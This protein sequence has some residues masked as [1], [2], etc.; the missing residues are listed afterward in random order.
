MAELDARLEGGIPRG[1]VSEVVGPRS[2]GRLAILVSALAAATSRGEAVALI[3]PLDMFDPVSA[4]AC[5]L[6]FQRMLWIRGEASSSARVSLSCE[7]GT[8]QKSLDRAVKALNIVLQAGGFGV[9]VLDLGEVAAQTIKR[10]PYTTWLRLHRVIEG[11]ETACVLIGSE[12]IARSAGGVTVQLTPGWAPGFGLER[13]CHP[14]PKSGERPACSRAF[15]CRRLLTRCT[16]GQ[17]QS[18]PDGQWEHRPTRRATTDRATHDPRALVQIARDFS[19]RVETHGD[20]TVTLDISGLGSLIGSPRSIGEELRR[21][22][23]DAGLCVHIAVASTST[24]AI[25]LAHA[26]AGVTVVAP[27][28]RSGGARA[29]AA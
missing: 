27:A 22:A 19:P 8:L 25:L 16:S 20:R 17:R 4:S 14:S 7:Y 12:P 29:V 21:T 24:T 3:D 13:A 5:G 9:V 15:I 1:H 18:R 6:D 23:A 26:R 11:S 2:S 28:N 10:L